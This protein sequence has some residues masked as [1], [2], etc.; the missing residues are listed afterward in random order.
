MAESAKQMDLPTGQRPARDAVVDT[1]QQS[2]VDDPKGTHGIFELPCGYLD[3]AQ[4]LHQ[5]VHV[6]EIT[7]VE[8]DMLGSKSI[9]NYKKIGSLI[10]A[11]IVRLGTI[12]DRAV[13]NTIA[14]KLTVGDRIFLMFAIRRVSLGDEYPFRSVCPNE[15]CKYKGLFTL[16]L[17]DLDI[18]KMPTPEKRI[19]DVTL[20]SGARLRFRPLVGKDE[21]ELAKARTV[22]EGRSLS[23]FLRTLMINDLP[24]TIEGVKA[25]SMRDRNALW[26]AMQ[27]VEGGVETT[28]DMQCPKCLE[29]FEQELN[30]GQMGFFFPSSVQKPSKTKSST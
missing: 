23:L 27:E 7:G 13:L 19:Y 6:R 28:M 8:E 10:S 1:L 9:P 18:K 21:E 26:D 15:N 4:V 22:S 30:V 17:S 20:P 5:E 25:L 2:K 12:T 14:E 29:E 16:D 3:E 11:C 24:P